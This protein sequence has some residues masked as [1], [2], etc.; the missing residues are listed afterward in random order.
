M[1]A[2]PELGQRISERHGFLLE[3]DMPRLVELFPKM[4]VLIRCNCGRHVVQMRKVAQ[5]IKEVE[6]DPH[7]Y[8]RDVSLDFSILR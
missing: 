6:R 5:K 4:E 3:S 8:V 2:D 7:D 1:D